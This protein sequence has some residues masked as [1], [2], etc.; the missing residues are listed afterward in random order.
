[1]MYFDNYRCPNCNGVLPYHN[2]PCRG[3]QPFPTYAPNPPGERP[4]P[5]PI[6]YVTAD[7]VRKIVREEIAQWMANQPVKREEG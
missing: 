5:M 1:M 6:Q 3:M 7:E 2:D 4:G